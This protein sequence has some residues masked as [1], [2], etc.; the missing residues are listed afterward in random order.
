MWLCPGQ[1]GFFVDKYPGGK[2]C[3]CYHEHTRRLLLCWF[4]GGW[5]VS[6]GLKV[7][8]MTQ[9]LNML[10]HTLLAPLLVLWRL[11]G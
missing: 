5:D 4:C 1:T 8:V 9:I 11:G 2:Y 7:K 6:V 3:T 10:T